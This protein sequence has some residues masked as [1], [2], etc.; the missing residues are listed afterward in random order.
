MKTWAGQLATTGFVSNVNERPGSKAE[1][2]DGASTD[3]EILYSRG[4]S[5][6]LYGRTDEAFRNL[7][8][9]T[10][11]ESRTKGRSVAPVIVPLLL[12]MCL[13]LSA[14]GSIAEFA[15][16]E[17][18]EEAIGAEIETDADGN[19]TLE[20]DEATVVFGAEEGSMSI[21]SD[22]G[23]FEMNSDNELP[24]GFP[25]PVPDGGTVVQSINFTGDDG[26]VFQALI[27]YPLSEYDRIADFYTN[28]FDGIEDSTRLEMTQNG[29]K[30]LNYTGANTLM[31]LSEDGQVVAVYIQTTDA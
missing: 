21:E 2:G 29:G 18:T 22:E 3:Y 15:V 12:A 28:H 25:V 27:N 16:E 30:A 7:A 1:R 6:L 13:A 8:E 23:S 24:E 14:C 5:S 10:A 11:V 26:V 19:I 17:V 31:N 20:S 9:E 4:S